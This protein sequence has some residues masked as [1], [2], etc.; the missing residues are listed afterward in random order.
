M[1]ITTHDK[2]LALLDS[3]K[4]DKAFELALSKQIIP[5]AYQ[6]FT[7]AVGSY[8]VV[9][10]PG[11]TMRVLVKKIISDDA[12]LIYVDSVPMAKTHNFGFERTYGARRRSRNGR[13]V[14]EPQQD[15]E[16]LAEQAHMMTAE[17][18]APKPRKRLPPEALKP[19]VRKKGVK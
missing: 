8:V 4:R 13:D 14:W 9:Q 1:A 5:G 16:F 18:A 12:I 11:E 2:M 3:R 6:R 7:P 17:E 15:R 19:A 10:M